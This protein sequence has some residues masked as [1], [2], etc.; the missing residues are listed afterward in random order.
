M[1]WFEDTLSRMDEWDRLG[2][3]F[4]L[5]LLVVCLG[6]FMVSAWW[7]W[8]KKYEREWLAS[9]KEEAPVVPFGVRGPL[10]RLSPDISIGELLNKLRSS[11]LVLSNDPG[12]GQLVLH[13]RKR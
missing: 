11:G 4:C 6:T 13:R 2:L 12:T 1:N 9:L 3:I 8:L 7:K 10:I 5:M